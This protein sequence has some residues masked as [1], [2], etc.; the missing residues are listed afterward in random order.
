MNGDGKNNK[1][2]WNKA[3]DIEQIHSGSY[4]LYKHLNGNKSNENKEDNFTLIIYGNIGNN[5]NEIKIEMFVNII[6]A[7]ELLK[8][9]HF[10]QELSIVSGGSTQLNSNLISTSHSTLDDSSIY[11]NIIQPPQNGIRIILKEDSPSISPFSSLANFT[12]KQINEG[13]IWLEHTPINEKQSWDVI[14]HSL[15]LIIRIEPLALQLRNFTDITYIQGK[16]YVILN[17]S[18]LGA[19]SNGDRSRIYYNITK[20]PENGTFYWVN[21]EKELNGFTQLNIDNNEVLYSQMNMNS[22]QDSFEFILSNDEL[23]LLPKKANIKVLPIFKPPTFVI[24]SRTILQLGLSHLNASELEG[25]SPRYLILP[26][27]VPRDGRFFVHPHSNESTLF[28]THDDIVNGRLYFHAFDVKY[29]T[30]NNVVVELRSDRVQPALI[31]W[32]IIIRPSDNIDTVNEIQSGIVEEEREHQY[33][34][35]PKQ[36]NQKTFLDNQIIPPPPPDMNYHFPIAILIAVVLLV[37]GILLCRKKTPPED[38][39]S[40]EEGDDTTRYQQQ[41]S[42]GTDSFRERNGSSKHKKSAP[43]NG[44][45]QNLD[46]SKN[47]QK[48]SVPSS[49][50]VTENE[51]RPKNILESTVYAAINN[52]QHKD[53]IV[54]RKL[55]QETESTFYSDDGGVYVGEENKKK[56]LELPLLITPSSTAYYATATIPSIISNQ[57]DITYLHTGTLKE[58]DLH[59]KK[60]RDSSRPSI[61]SMRNDSKERQ[62]LLASAVNEAF[63]NTRSADG[64]RKEFLIPNEDNEQLKIEQENEEKGK[65]RGKST[66]FWV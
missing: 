46:S 3:L 43:E 66:E 63:A 4:L 64:R 61:L 59:S 53:S 44:I 17:R 11:F 48:L 7:S 26:D 15:V 56:K 13:S 29:R 39:A 41:K 40:S 36:Q 6:E 9:H 45:N 20:P 50:L 18:H 58:K 21:G 2:K 55:A 52:K 49:C 32:P 5:E 19:E 30:V 33:K 28:F 14:G 57:S 31:H 24:N 37:V 34:S 23:E 38:I 16:N 10:P 35:Q 8:I 22:Y 51:I 25:S 47:Q 42:N 54:S 65:E 60:R 62:Q 12:Q 27:G 1:Y